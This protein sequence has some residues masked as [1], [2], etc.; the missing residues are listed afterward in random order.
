M[1]FVVILRVYIICISSISLRNHISGVMVSVLAL[2]VV[3]L[4]VLSPDRVKPTIMKFVLVASPLSTK[5]KGERARN[6]YVSEWDYM[7]TCGLLFQ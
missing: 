7:F 4:W 3:D 6:Q 1:E 2:S 5:H